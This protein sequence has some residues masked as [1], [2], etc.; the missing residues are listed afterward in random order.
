MNFNARTNLIDH[1]S[2]RFGHSICNAGFIFRA[3]LIPLQ[4][5]SNNM[6]TYR[7]MSRGKRESIKT[8]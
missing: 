3:L 4:V 6:A 5:V 1:R 7:G 8:S 2:C